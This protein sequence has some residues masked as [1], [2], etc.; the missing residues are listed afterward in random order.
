LAHAI[1]RRARPT[2]SDSRPAPLQ[3]DTLG[4]AEPGVR[5]LNVPMS[6][7]LRGPRWLTLSHRAS[8]RAVTA[9]HGALLVLGLISAQLSATKAAEEPSTPLPTLRTEYAF[10]AHVSVGSAII[11]GQGPQG[12]RRY[13]PIV[14]GTVDGPLLSGKVLPAG[15]DSQ[16]VRSDGVLVVDAQ[17]VIQTGDGV[18]I[19]VFNRGL[20][21]G[22]KEVIA[23]LTR[24]EKV[25][26]NEYYFRTA[27]QFEAPLGSRYEWLNQ[28]IFVATAERNPNETVIHFYRIL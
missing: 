6:R 11:V 28:A 26:P 25:S 1:Q 21:L 12:I 23:K 17:Y 20:R 3:P 24:G 18:N 22:S 15:G 8:R 9:T 5:S 13:I 27:A 10:T 14:G 16:V 2:S 4:P 19:A 7:F